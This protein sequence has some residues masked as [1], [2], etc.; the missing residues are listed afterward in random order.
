MKDKEKVK[1]I[2]KWW[3]KEKKLLGLPVVA[4]GASSGGY[5]IS[6]LATEFNF[7]SLTIM[8]AE[9]RIKLMEA[10]AK[11]PPTLFVHM[12]NDV[13]RMEFVANTMEMLK[14]KG[15]DV[16]EVKFLEFPLTPTFLLDIIPGLDERTSLRFF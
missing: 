7:D 2:L 5:F 4:L 16:T 13:R 1:S 14:I 3:L 15:I 8:I 11:F 12:P 6:A 9:G 10:Q